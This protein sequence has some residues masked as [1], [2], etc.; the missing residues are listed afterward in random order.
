MFQK[1]GVTILVKGNAAQSLDRINASGRRVTSTLG[2]IERGNGRYN[3][4]A[5]K[6]T[7][8]NKSMA[9]SSAGAMSSL[10]SSGTMAMTA[11]AAGAAFVGREAY[12]TT[13]SF[14]KLETVLTTA[15]GS[16]SAARKSFEDIRKFA[17]DSPEEVLNVTD[18]FVKFANRG[19]RL[20]KDEM[21]SLGDV[22]LS[23][24]GTFQQLS[25]AILD[26]SNS[27]RWNELGIKA[28]K[29][30]DKITLTYRGV[31]KTVADTEVAVKN[32]I[33][34]FGKMNGIQ[35]MG[36]KVAKTLGGQESILRDTI[37][38]VSYTMGSQFRPAFMAGIQAM[39]GTVKSID[40]YLQKNPQFLGNL[41]NATISVIQLTQKITGLAMQ[42]LPHFTRNIN[43][44]TSVIGGVA[45][46]GGDV[47]DW[48]GKSI[49][50]WDKMT[51]S[52][53]GYIKAIDNINSE[54]VANAIRGGWGAL[55]ATNQGRMPG[56]TWS[57][58]RTRRFNEPF[59]KAEE[60]KQVNYGKRIQE[61]EAAFAKA[62]GVAAFQDVKVQYGGKQTALKN[63]KG[64]ERMLALNVK[65]GYAEFLEQQA[66]QLNERK[67]IIG[68]MGALGGKSS[69]GDGTSVT[70]DK[71]QSRNIVIN[72]AKQGI[73]NVN[74]HTTTLK[75]GTAKVVD[76]L[77]EELL[78]VVND[79]QIMAN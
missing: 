29:N 25:E 70:G 44:A 34:S 54:K 42:A 60:Q 79:A 28:K 33:V 37:S 7:R 24:G 43:I 10:A 6:L 4:S 72:I 68:S 58:Y 50:A 1:Y 3:A 14:D 47:L 62:S 75:E 17:A 67:N 19:V 38:E 52:V 55:S 15:L 21:V 13:A 9:S 16:N 56:E 12:N 49:P 27:E 71:I 46:V 76:I 66:D 61:A 36:S 39:T 74:I 65:G 64:Y 48:I 73:D 40:A 45:Q 23:T 2:N 69:S 77:R 31:S 5:M 32:A 8:A 22:A 30:G 53:G 11:I 57:Q 63:L 18:S 78:R 26:K 51:A 59:Q 35:G 41:S 20:A